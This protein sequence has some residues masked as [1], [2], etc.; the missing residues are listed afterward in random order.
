LSSAGAP[1]LSLPRRAA[2]LSGQRPESDS[3]VSQRIHLAFER[4]IFYNVHID[5]GIFNLAKEKPMA[6]PGEEITQLLAQLSAE[7]QKDVAEYA[8]YLLSLQ[9][10][11]Q[12]QRRRFYI[13]PTCFDVSE[14]MIE[15]HG[16]LMVSCNTENP[17][18]CKPLMDRNGELK[19]RAPRWFINAVARVAAG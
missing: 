2:R 17:E 3:A 7:N 18:D 12:K 16:H 10:Q 4:Y 11:P 8:A 19:T 1:L 5:A 13:C 6:E 15:C 9:K 14:Q